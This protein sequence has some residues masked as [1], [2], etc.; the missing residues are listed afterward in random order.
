MRMP[1]R[2]PARNAAI[3]RL[4]KPQIF[5]LMIF[6]FVSCAV[7]TTP[8]RCLSP[9]YLTCCDALGRGRPAPALRESS[10]RYLTDITPPQVIGASKSH[11]EIQQF[12]SM[13]EIGGF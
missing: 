10:R 9:V 4:W 5:L 6:P 3:F 8:P 7:E 11:E 2:S 12:I 13:S 1:V